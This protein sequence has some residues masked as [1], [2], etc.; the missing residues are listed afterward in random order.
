[1]VSPTNILPSRASRL[2]FASPRLAAEVPDADETVPSHSRDDPVAAELHRPEDVL[3]PGQDTPIDLTIFVSCYEEESLIIS[4]LDAIR[5]SLA[6][7]K[8]L[9]YE[10]IVIDDCSRDRSADL[11][12]EYI[13]AHP[14]DRIMLRRNKVNHGLAQNYFDAAFIGKGKY[15]RLICGDNAE[16]E[17]TMVAVFRAIGKADMVIPYYVTREGKGFYRKLL[18][19]AY[20]QIVNT[21]G[22]QNLHYY[23][24]LAV[25]LRYNVMRWHPNTRGFG[26]QADI[27]SLLL[28]QGFTYIEVPV[29]DNEKKRGESRALTFKNLLSVTHTLV[30]I[31]IRRISNR[32]YRPRRIELMGRAWRRVEDVLVAAV[33]GLFLSVTLFVVFATFPLWLFINWRTRRFY[34]VEAERSLQRT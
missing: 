33:A 8:E 5:K 30:D 25:H 23:N 3:S 27:I 13:R 6:A 18:S 32:V 10:L 31:V 34:K 17:E 2:Q 28:D 19:L 12:E 4:T 9:T 24:G 16:P 26:F 14:A 15:Y 20:S 29:K 11:V 1:M 7:V 21:I 22:S